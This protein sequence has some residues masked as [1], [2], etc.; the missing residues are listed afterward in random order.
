MSRN[1]HPWFRKDKFNLTIW[2]LSIFSKLFLQFFFTFSRLQT[3]KFYWSKREVLSCQLYRQYVCG[4]Q[5][6]SSHAKRPRLT[7]QSNRS[8]SIPPGNLNVWIILVQI[9]P[10]L[11]QKA[12]QMPCHRFISGYRMLLPLGKLRDYCFNFSVASIMLL[13]LRM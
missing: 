1:D 5:G 2:A 13:K 12:V 6:D 8:F 3:I 11:G 7:Y 4:R 10:T 9:P